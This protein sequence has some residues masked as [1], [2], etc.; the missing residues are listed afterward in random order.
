MI[1][2]QWSQ[3]GNYN[4]SCEGQSIIHQIEAS[5]RYRVACFARFPIPWSSVE[6]LKVESLKY[7]ARPSPVLSGLRAD[8]PLYL[9]F[10][11]NLSFPVYSGSFGACFPFFL[12][13]IKV[14]SNYFSFSVYIYTYIYI[15]IYIHIYIYVCVCIYVYIYKHACMHITLAWR[16][17]LIFWLA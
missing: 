13:M 14:Y 17:R 7:C 12:G 5:A 2:K 1:S 6:S 8:G 10:P 11:L 9:Q 16:L 3:E 15:Y 4:F